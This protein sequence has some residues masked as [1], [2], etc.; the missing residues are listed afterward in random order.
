MRCSRTS[1]PTSRS[2]TSRSTSPT[3]ATTCRAGAC[4]PALRFEEVVEAAA[5]VA[6]AGRVGRGVALDGHPQ[7]ERGALVA[8]GLVGDPLDERLGALEAPARVEVAALPAGPD[9]GAAARALLE[10][11]V[12]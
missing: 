10:R 3:P 11:R 6:G 5:D 1:F 4:P 2:A 8:R 12:G 7:G 9:G